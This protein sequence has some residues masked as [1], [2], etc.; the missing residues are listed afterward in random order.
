MPS[1]EPTFRNLCLNQRVEVMSPFVSKSV[2]KANGGAVD[3]EVFLRNPVFVA[4]DLSGKVDLTSMALIAFEDNIWHAKVF[5]WTPLN[6][7]KERALRDRAPYDVW[8]AAGL[9]RTITGSA[10]DYEA[11]AKDMAEILE[12]MDVHAVAF[13]RWR[14]DLLKKE[15][16]EIGLDLNLVPF[17]QGFKDMAPALDKT[18]EV[19][20]NELLV[21]GNN[22]V[23]TMCMS[24]ARVEKDAAGN[25]KLNKAKATGRIDGAV[26]L[27]M[28]MGLAASEEVQEDLDDF[29]FNPIQG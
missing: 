21:H 4:L 18:E 8:V 24:N 15:L 1:F 25:R 16:D 22:P 26:A 14:F 23:L 17:G 29:I 19:L 7:V 5:F 3:D 13:D 20:M 27:T 12:G 9:I 11:I 6:G 10:I 28:A 2:W